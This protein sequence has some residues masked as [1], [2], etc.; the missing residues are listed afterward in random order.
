MHGDLKNTISWNFD[1]V[2]TLP[3]VAD[4]FLL[5]GRLGIQSSKNSDLFLYVDPNRLTPI[6]TR[7]HGY[8]QRCCRTIATLRI[9]PP[10]REA[11]A[12]AE[13]A[14]ASPDA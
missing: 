14:K 12:A 6:A 9:R 13:R 1:V 3:I 10:E 8:R 2:G 5:L 4:W 11:A 7:E